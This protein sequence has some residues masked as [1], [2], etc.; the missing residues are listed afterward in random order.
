MTKTWHTSHLYK[1]CHCQQVAYAMKRCFH[2]FI[3]QVDFHI[4][5]ASDLSLI[6]LNTPAGHWPRLPQLWIISSK[7]AW[8]CSSCL[9]LGDACGGVH[10]A[11]IATAGHNVCTLCILLSHPP[12]PPK[13]RKTP[14]SCLKSFKAT[15]EH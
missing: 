11:S 15:Q 5:Q 3:F 4:C 14:L 7:G 13:K 2:L 8:R 10:V 9:V 12:I 6:N 1:F